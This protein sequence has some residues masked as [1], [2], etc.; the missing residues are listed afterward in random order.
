MEYG[1]VVEK[2]G[3]FLEKKLEESGAEGFVV[4]MSGGIDS[5]TVTKLAV[6][7]LG[8]EKVTGWIM[9]GDPSDPQNMED[10]RQLAEDLGITYR[11]VDIEPV[12][13]K[14][15]EQAPFELGKVAEG[16]IRA[17]LRM[18]YEYMEANENDMM[19]MGGA[20]KTERGIGYFTKYG[21]GAVDINPIGDLY[22]TEVRELAKH[23]DLDRKFIEKAPT[24][25]L[26]KEQTDESEL[27]ASYEVI[28]AILKRL[29]E[30]GKSRNQ[31][32][33]ETGLEEQT[34][35]RF[36]EMHHNSEHKRTPPNYPE[37]R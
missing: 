29:V 23:I 19:V 7:T 8:P 17:R 22:K 21:D 10:A 14:Y 28:D 3:D 5:A 12:V 35:D 2:V 24:A 27:G 1:E 4:G 11:E 6:E 13:E 31:I 20:N 9:P 16:N 32:L 37:L 15:L 26:W 18:I 33:E 34:V 36:I 25:G 30:E